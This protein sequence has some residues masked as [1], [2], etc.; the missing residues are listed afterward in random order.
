MAVG[1]IMGILFMHPWFQFSNLEE[2]KTKHKKDNDDNINNKV[3]PMKLT[4]LTWKLSVLVV[5]NFLNVC[6]LE[7]RQE[8]SI[9][10]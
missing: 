6:F 4:H 5:R 9:S 1:I 3:K 2:A 7:E 10:D 8:T